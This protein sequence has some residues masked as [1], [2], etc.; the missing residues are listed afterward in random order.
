[1]VPKKGDLIDF[2]HSTLT[3]LFHSSVFFFIQLNLKCRF[4]GSEQN[5]NMNAKEFREFGYAAVD[6]IADYMENVHERFVSSDCDYKISDK[7]TD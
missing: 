3:H 5:T 6:F 1:M 4:D 2:I 7:K